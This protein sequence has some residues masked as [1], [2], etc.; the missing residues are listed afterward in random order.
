MALSNNSTGLFRCPSCEIEQPKT[1]FTIRKCG[2]LA[3]YCKLCNATRTAAYRLRDHENYLKLR[4][5]AR[6]QYT[7]NNG[8]KAIRKNWDNLSLEEQTNQ[9]CGIYCITIGPK[10][11][12]GSAVNFNKRIKEHTR[13]LG[14]GRHINAYVQSSFNKYQTFDAEVI[15]FC[16]PTDLGAREQFYIDQWFSNKDCLNL[17]PDVKTML[18]FKHSDAT[19]KKLSVIVS[20]H[21]QEIRNGTK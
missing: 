15:E 16:A 1:G 13:N 6:R 4:R 5:E 9:A 10:F 3:S 2:K 12:I 21:Q 14:K 7:K 11:Y 8:S 19:K 18:G 20:A 17:R